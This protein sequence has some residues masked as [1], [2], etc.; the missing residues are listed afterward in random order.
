LA[1]LGDQRCYDEIGKT[2][3]KLNSP[4]YER[5]INDNDHD[6]AVS[7]YYTLTCDRPCPQRCPSGRCD[8]T[9]GH[10]I[11]IEPG[12]FGPTCDRPCPPFMFGVNCEDHCRC[13]QELSTGCAPLV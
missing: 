6:N 1:H 13:E 8:R 9:Y 11:C 5:T 3:L 12:L 4:L 2:E 7:G 10:C